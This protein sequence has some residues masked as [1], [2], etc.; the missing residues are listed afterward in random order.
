M[1][2]R[3]NDLLLKG[4]GEVP[5]QPKYDLRG[6]NFA[7]GFAE[8]VQGNQIGGIQY[9][10]ASEQRQNLAE[11]AAE[12]QQL[13]KQLS[14]SYPTDTTAQ[15]MVVVAKAVETIESTPK[16]RLRVVNAMKS[17][18]TEALKQIVDHPLI[19]I[20]LAALEGFQSKG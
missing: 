14:Q 13:L 1:A 19:N 12:I 15:K 18:G 3:R 17:G 9:N 2:E 10:Y 7:G 4:V 8:T 11:A 20:L 6:A 16:L 5:E